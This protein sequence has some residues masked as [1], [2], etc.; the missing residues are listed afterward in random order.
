MA[1]SASEFVDRNVT[2]VQVANA[3]NRV[4]DA[5]D[6]LTALA[7]SRG[8]DDAPLTQAL[9]A[10]LTAQTEFRRTVNAL[11]AEGV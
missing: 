10:V 3:S 2:R 11:L 4:E 6:K 5:L 8:D 7:V 9:A 1:I